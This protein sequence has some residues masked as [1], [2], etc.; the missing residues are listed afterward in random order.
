MIG[1]KETE[2]PWIGIFISIVNALAIG[3]TISVV[4]DN[5]SGSDATATATAFL[6][7]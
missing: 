7:K 3:V 6:Q 2:Y 1:N 5:F 4:G